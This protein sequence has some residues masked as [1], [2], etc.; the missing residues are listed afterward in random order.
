MPCGLQLETPPTAHLGSLQGI[1]HEGRLL[2]L[3]LQGGGAIGS[4]Y[5]KILPHYSEDHYTTT[6]IDTLDNS[7]TE[8]DV[9]VAEF[10]DTL[11]DTTKPVNNLRG[12]VSW[13]MAATCNLPYPIKNLIGVLCIAQP[14][15]SLVLEQLESLR[16]RTMD[17]TLK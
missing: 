15:L 11:V 14:G 3:C 5:R 7:R 13:P 6:D 4:G 10:A 16:A 17:K 9:H 2:Q 1:E 12:A 8:G